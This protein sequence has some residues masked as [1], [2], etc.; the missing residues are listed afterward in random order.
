M[1]L[2]REAP[3]EPPIDRSRW[4]IVVGLA[5]ILMGC[6]CA[7]IGIL[8]ALFPALLARSLGPGGLSDGNIQ[9]SNSLMFAALAL[10]FVWLGAGTMRAR[11]WA[12]DMMLVT[13]WF[14]LAT[15]IL[16]LGLILFVLPGLL[17]RMSDASQLQLGKSEIAAAMFFLMVVLGFF[18]VAL[19]GFFVWFYSHRDVKSTFETRDRNI[20]WTGKCPLSV[21][22]VSQFMAGSAILF[23]I[24]PVFSDSMPFFGTAVRGFAFWLFSI[25]SAA[26]SAYLAWA[27]YRCKRHAW[28]INFVFTAA[29]LIW[30]LASYGSV[31]MPS[32]GNAALTPGNEMLI[33]SFFGPRVL[34]AA[35]GIAGAAWMVFLML[36]KKHFRKP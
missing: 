23:L 5:E 24:A 6:G 13:A 14:W 7:L 10:L 32:S 4:L 22:T 35:S 9:A 30:L 8:L 27:V 15:G 36:T 33:G 18:Y 12:R 2:F 28:W 31:E 17:L 19:P 34:T 29:I 25:L 26:L 11:R 16:A 3:K 20:R 21:L 1:S